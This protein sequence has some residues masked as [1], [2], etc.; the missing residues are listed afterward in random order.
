MTWGALPPWTRQ[1]PVPV[2]AGSLHGF[3]RVVCAVHRAPRIIGSSVAWVFDSSD[4]FKG[5]GAEASEAPERHAAGPR[6]ASSRAC[7]V[8]KAVDV[9]TRDSCCNLSRAW[10][11]RLTEED[12][13]A[14]SLLLWGHVNPYGLFRLDMETR[15]AIEKA[16]CVGQ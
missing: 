2:T 5:R 6:K 16:E 7:A 14:L 8:E 13:R 12:R 10:A 11:D 9:F 15:L 3:P 4:S 1:T